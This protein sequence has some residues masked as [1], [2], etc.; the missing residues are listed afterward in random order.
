M[1]EFI[2]SA[3]QNPWIQALLLGMLP[4][5]LVD[6]RAFLTWDAEAGGG[7][8]FSATISLLRLALGAA[9][10]VIGYV[11]TWAN[12]YDSF[13]VQSAISGILS[14]IAVDLTRFFNLSTVEGLRTFQY[15]PMFIRAAQGLVIGLLTGYGIA[16]PTGSVAA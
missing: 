5:F 9:S 13:V 3:V 16:I 15:K 6:L 7:Q 10:G 11:G 12:L 4:A 1:D 8:K 14:G 2:K